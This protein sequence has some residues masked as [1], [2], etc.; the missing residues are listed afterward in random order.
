MKGTL[1]LCAGIIIHETGKRDIREMNGI[2]SKLP[3]TMLAFSVA[4][5]GMMGTP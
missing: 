4:A 2:G 5:L 3:I 1:F